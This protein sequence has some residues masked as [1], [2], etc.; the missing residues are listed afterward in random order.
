MRNEDDNEAFRHDWQKFRGM[1]NEKFDDYVSVDNHLAS[2]RVN[3]VEQLCES[4]VGATLLKGPEE[5]GEDTEPEV[6]PNFAEALRNVKSFVCAHSNSD[7][8][9][10]GVL[11]L[12]SSFFELTC[13]VSTRQLSVTEFFF[14]QKN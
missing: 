8:D 2:S 9:R 12:L 5:E 3:T 1:D 6:V 11:S 7:G 14:F 4:H 10:D 13:R